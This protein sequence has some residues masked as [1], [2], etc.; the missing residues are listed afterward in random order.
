M[1]VWTADPAVASPRPD[2]SPAARF[3][4]AIIASD[5]HLPFGGTRH[6]GYDRELAVAG[7]REFTN[8]TYWVA[9]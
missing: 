3:V 4:N 2:G 1:S 6:S 9:A 5:P 8:S 7:I